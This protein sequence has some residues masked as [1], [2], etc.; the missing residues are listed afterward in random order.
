M[1]PL[2]TPTNTQSN[3]IQLNTWDRWSVVKLKKNEPVYYN[4]IFFVE[5]YRL[6]DLHV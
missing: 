6:F 2:T 4:D 3:N 5:K 1:Y